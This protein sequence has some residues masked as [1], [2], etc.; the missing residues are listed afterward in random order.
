MTSTFEDDHNIEARIDQESPKPDFYK[1]FLSHYNQNELK[2]L[3]LF[4]QD[5]DF[6]SHIFLKGLFFEYGVS[7]LLESNRPAALEAYQKGA[8]KRDSYCNLRLHFIY[9]KEFKAFGVN[10]DRFLEMLHLIKAAAYFDEKDNRINRKFLDPVMHLAVHLDNEDPDLLKCVDL[11]DKYKILNENNKRAG[12]FLHNWCC[13]RFSLSDIT[14]DE[15]LNNLTSLAEGKDPEACY[16]LGEAYRY[17]EECR[18]DFELSKKYLEIAKE[19]GCVKAIESLGYLY[20]LN[21]KPDMSLQNYKEGARIGSY[22]SLKILGEY[23]IVGKYTQQ[24]FEQG[25]RN[26]Y[27]A[28]LQCDFWAL[29]TMYEIYKYLELKEK[30]NLAI[31]DK[32]FYLAKTLFEIKNKIGKIAHIRLAY[33]VY[34]ECFEKG[35]GIKQDLNQSSMVL[36]KSLE[37]IELEKLKTFIY[38]RLAIIS[39]QQKEYEEA[40]KYYDLCIRACLLMVEGYNIIRNRQN[41]NHYKNQAYYYLLGKLLYLG[42]GTARNPQKAIEYL[43]EGV[44]MENFFY[45]GTI[46]SRKCQN[47]LQKIHTGESIIRIQGI[48]SNE[49][50]RGLKR[51]KVMSMFNLRDIHFDIY[52][53]TEGPVRIFY[54]KLKDQPVKLEEYIYSSQNN[55][56]QILSHLASLINV[57]HSSLEEIVGVAADPKTCEIVTIYKPFDFR[58]IPLE[59]ITEMEMI[60]EKSINNW[61]LE[62]R[63]SCHKSIEA[64]DNSSAERAPYKLSF[65][66]KI[67]FCLKVTGAIQSLHLEKFSHGNLTPKNIYLSQNNDVIISGYGHQN[68]KFYDNES[69]FCKDDTIIVGEAVRYLAPETFQKNRIVETS[70][71]IWSLGC[72]M[73]LIF[74]EKPPLFHLNTTDILQAH[75]KKIAFDLKFTDETPQSIQD[76]IKQC[77]DADPKS[78]NDSSYIIHILHT[79]KS[80]FS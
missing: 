24:D 3:W 61:K 70:S 54:G 37:K 71:D 56:I 63:L 10:K 45:F 47:L 31:Q 2:D 27:Y 80:S 50:A 44:R 35:Y 33:S 51:S 30:K 29:L 4:L 9:K 14:K 11:L 25:L 66:Q 46:F 58:Y 36:L 19:N 40:N 77:I 32:M 79:V 43:K 64:E 1:I 26:I 60:S 22:T 28:Y 17:G 52:I 6:G 65:Q 48:R 59:N 53:N 49:K 18:Q 7:P 15:C 72:L 41:H 69:N 12:D 55:Y 76:L 42:R 23:Q 78:R 20:Q 5:S 38:Y 57:K 8:D 68:P 73:Y 62:P 75:K 67:D 16:F 21:K 13:I 74:T 39:E 34:A